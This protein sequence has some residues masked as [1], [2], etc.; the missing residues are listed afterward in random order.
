MSAYPPERILPDTYNLKPS[1]RVDKAESPQHYNKWAIEPIEYVMK[2]E[3]GYCEGNVVK[4]ITRWRD[5]GG[6]EDLIKAKRYIDI[7]LEN[8]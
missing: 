2:N 1:T 3:L 6:A 5:K 8:M 7:L 4:Y